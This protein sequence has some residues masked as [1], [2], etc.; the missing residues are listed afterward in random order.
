MPITGPRRIPE[1]KPV[2]DDEDDVDYDGRRGMMAQ[3]I[4]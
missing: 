4:F 3:N 2:G 1:S